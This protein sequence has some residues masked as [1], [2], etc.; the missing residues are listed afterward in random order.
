MQ[1]KNLKQDIKAILL[2]TLAIFLGLSLVSYHPIDPSLNS[3]GNPLSDIHNYCGYVGSFL[4]DFLYQLFGLQSWL[5][6]YILFHWSSICF[7]RHRRQKQKTS[8]VY[9][10]ALW[11]LCLLMSVN[12]LIDMYFPGKRI[13]AQHILLSGLIGHG[14]TSGLRSLFNPLGGQILLWGMSL[15][16]WILIGNRLALLFYKICGLNLSLCEKLYKRLPKVLSS[17]SI[18]PLARIFSQWQKALWDQSL[19]ES[20]SGGE[21]ESE[22]ETRGDEEVLA[23]NVY[24]PPPPFLLNLYLLQNLLVFLIK[25]KWR[26]RRHCKKKQRSQKSFLLYLILPKKSFP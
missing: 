1:I 7:F 9:Y 10:R 26:G 14:I 19:S 25:M 15:T 18:Q 24:Y 16:F 21:N 23:G 13:F 2:S 17:Y 20:E 6:V 12:G 3:V 22:N 11:V 4:S 8:Q 5:L